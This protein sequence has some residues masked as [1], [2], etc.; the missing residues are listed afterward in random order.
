MFIKHKYCIFSMCSKNYR[1]AYDF[2]IESWLKTDVEKIV[3]YTDDKDWKSNNPRI[4]I[5]KIFEPSTDWLVNTGRRSICTQHVLD[6]YNYEKLIFLDIDCYVIKNISHVFDSNFDIAVVRWSKKIELSAG[7][8]FINKNSKTQ[9]FGDD[10]TTHAN[11]MKAKQIGMA[12]HA[13]SYAQIGYDKLIKSRAAKGQ[14]NV[15]KLDFS[16]YSIKIKRL[17]TKSKF[18]QAFK[19]TEQLFRSLD[20]KVLHFYNN[21]YREEDTVE[22]ALK[23]A[24]LNINKFPD[25]N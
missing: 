17:S 5:V 11:K 25:K 6:N 21:S 20:I 22:W 7:V 15:L 3:I 13:G 18:P 23:L 19:N 14:Y 1:D 16:Q 4:D 12:A 24:E 8:F 2:V 10:W 9:S